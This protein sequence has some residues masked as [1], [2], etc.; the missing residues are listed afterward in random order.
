MDDRYRVSLGFQRE[1]EGWQ[2]RDLCPLE[3]SIPLSRKTFFFFTKTEIISLSPRTLHFLRSTYTQRARF[4][5]VNFSKEEI[6]L[7]T[8]IKR[9]LIRVYI[10]LSSLSSCRCRL[11]SLRKQKIE[12]YRIIFHCSLF[13]DQG[14]IFFRRVTQFYVKFCIYEILEFQSAERNRGFRKYFALNKCIL[15]QQGIRVHIRRK[16]LCEIVA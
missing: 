4:R 3:R 15:Y 8:Y 16:S 9:E 7:A 13:N 14:K 12:L 11:N 10:K 2:K 5:A 6:F 1:E